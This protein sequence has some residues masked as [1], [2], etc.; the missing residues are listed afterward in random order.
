[1]KPLLACALLSLPAFAFP[2]GYNYCKLVTTSVS[3]VSGPSDL[4]N[5]P[6]TV[7]VTDADLK[8]TASGGLV[9][10]IS[11]HDIAFY[12][13]CSGTGTALKWEIESYTASTGALVAHVLRPVLSHVANDTIGLYYGGS[14]T[15]FQSTPSAVWDASYKGVYHLANGSTLSAA[16]SAA[17]GLGNGTIINGV[18]ATAGKVDGGALFASASTRYVDLGNTGAHYS[19]MTAEAWING[20]AFPASAKEILTKGYDGSKTE[21]EL[22]V[23]E[24]GAGKVEFSTY[25]GAKHGVTTSVATLSPGTW[26]HVA[27][28]FD[29]STWRLYING[30]QDSFSND[31]TGPQS[32]AR[33]IFTGA[34]DSGGA[35]GNFDG[36]IDEVRI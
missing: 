16:D 10:N 34:V 17:S 23:G 5:Y 1:M 2:N 21:W 4:A 9:N 27:G 33:K 7:M 18:A 14:F 6:L 12:P 32:T 36:T 24:F 8:S 11:G 22:G 25:N 26:Y 15:T 20:T 29:G 31:T 35:F 30:N 28:T 3:M 13:D 19:N